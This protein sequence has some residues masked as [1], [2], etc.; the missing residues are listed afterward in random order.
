M[1]ASVNIDEQAKRLRKVDELV[2]E[3]EKT[4]QK[5]RAQHERYR[6]QQQQQQQK[7][8]E[9]PEKNFESSVDD[10]DGEEDTTQSEQKVPIASNS[11]EE[12]FEEESDQPWR[13]L[14]DSIVVREEAIW[15]L[16]DTPVVQ[17]RENQL[18]TIPKLLVAMYS[19]EE[20]EVPPVQT[21]RPLDS[22]YLSDLDASSTTTS[23]S[24]PLKTI[25]EGSEEER[26]VV[27][28]ASPLATPKTQ[29]TKDVAVETVNTPLRDEAVS[30]KSDDDGKEED[31]IKPN[32]TG[33]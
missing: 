6:E 18:N 22:L 27:N 13:Y 4:L 8:V 5:I 11:Q 30:T 15:G 23:I 25:S 19:N 17:K 2:Q 21:P 32:K 33:I 1:A 12:L 14:K 20:P 31:E 28:I 26:M 16:K 7:I 3:A 9:E 10:Y 24:A 29:D